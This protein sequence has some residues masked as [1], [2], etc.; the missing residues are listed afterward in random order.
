M[1]YQIVGASETKY[2]ADIVRRLIGEGWEPQ[3]GIAV[4]T[5]EGMIY[6]A[7]IRRREDD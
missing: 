6:Q 7:M 4:D 1:E 5:E 3:G 2:L